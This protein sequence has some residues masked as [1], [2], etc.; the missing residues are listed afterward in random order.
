MF[1]LFLLGTP[2]YDHMFSLKD[3]M[4]W[5]TNIFW[6]TVCQSYWTMP[7]LIINEIYGSYMLVPQSILDMS[8]EF[9]VRLSTLGSFWKTETSKIKR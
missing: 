7:Y 5:V 8:Q 1:R 2:L 9:S 4:V 6:S 3:S